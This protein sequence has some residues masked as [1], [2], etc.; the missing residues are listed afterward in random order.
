VP[1]PVPRHRL[2]A[3]DKTSLTG[4]R[5]NLP[6]GAM[7]INTKG[8]RVS[9][10]PYDRSDGFSPGSAIVIH[11]AGL[12]SV[13]AL[14]RTGAVPLTDMSRYLA[15]RQPIVVLDQSTGKRQLI[16]AEMDANATDRANT[17]LL[18]HPGKNFTEGHTYIVALRFL[19]TA[20]G[21][22]IQSPAWFARLRDGS[23]LPAN[24]RGQRTRYHAIFRVLRRAK[25]ATDAA[26]R[27]RGASPSPPARPSPGGCWRSA[28]MPSRN[29]ATPTSPIPSC[30]ARRRSSP[31]PPPRR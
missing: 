20:T 2:T 4:L 6:S 18:I 1:A 7:P 27:R 5:V 29:S 28:T 21:K 10:A 26:S 30:R 11:V 31:S 23:R 24:L 13:A 15:K 17:D 9:P 16:W 14:A 8:I 19:K 22:A 3:H 12:D 25:I